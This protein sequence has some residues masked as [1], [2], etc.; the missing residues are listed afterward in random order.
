MQ[1]EKIKEGLVLIAVPIELLN[2]VSV[3]YTTPLQMYVDKNRLVIERLEDTKDVVCDD[4]CAN[5]P[6]KESECDKDCK[7]CSND[8]NKRKEI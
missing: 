7:S 1:S 5:C 2:E 6:I 3:G 8:C 4:D